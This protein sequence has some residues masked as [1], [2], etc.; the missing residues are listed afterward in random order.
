MFRLLLIVMF[1]E[2]QY[3]Y[4]YT[5]IYLLTLYMSFGLYVLPE[6]VFK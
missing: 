5:K 3:V 4:V 6:D 1:S 2:Q